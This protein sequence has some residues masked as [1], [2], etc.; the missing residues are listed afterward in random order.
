MIEHFFD[1]FKLICREP[2]RY[3]RTRLFSLTEAEKAVL[4]DACKICLLKGIPVYLS[5]GST[6]NIKIT[7]MGDY[8]IAKAL[9]QLSAQQDS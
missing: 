2:E 3:S 4:T 9:T 7:T 6:D 8:N 1:Q 5:K